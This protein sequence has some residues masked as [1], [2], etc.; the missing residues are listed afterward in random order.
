MFF[1]LHGLVMLMKQ[2]SYAFC[3]Y[4]ASS[5][6]H[7]LMISDNG[8]LSENLK[9]RDTLLRKLKQLDAIAPVQTPSATTPAPDSLFTSYLDQKPTASELSH[10]RQSLHASSATTDDAAFNLAQVATAIE[11]GEP[12]DIDQIQIFERIIKW[13]IDALS[14]DLKGK[15]TNPAK[16]YPNNLTIANH[17]EYIVLPTLVYELEY[18]RSDEINWYYVAEKLVATFG[19]LLVMNLCSQAYIY[20]IVVQTIEMKDAGVPLIERLQ[21]FPR[22]ISDLIFP[23]MLEY[24]MVCLPSPSPSPLLSFPFLSLL[25]RADIKTDMVCDLGMHPQ[26]PRGAH[27]LRRP[28]LLRRLVELGILGPVRARLEPPRAQLPAA[29]RLPLLYLFAQGQQVHRDAHHVLPVCVRARAG[30]VVSVQETE[31]LSVVLA[32]DAAPARSDE[33]DEMA[34]GEEDAGELDLLGWHLHGAESAV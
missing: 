24:M 11:S 3:K 4:H 5:Y 34:E 28:G 6:L 25:S 7:P 2:H 21:H 14:D 29:P 27:V 10:R 18:P 31:R 13:E 16:F 26:S 8:H 33:S 30:H 17:Y 20:P 15:S 1:V 19:I 23:F 22:M 12:L 32:D 9:M